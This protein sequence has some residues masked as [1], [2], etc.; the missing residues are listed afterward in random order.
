MATPLDDL[1][2]Q[3]ARR[4]ALLKERYIAQQLALLDLTPLSAKALGYHVVS[5]AHSLCQ[6]SG[7][8]VTI[9]LDSVRIRLCECLAFRKL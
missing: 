8:V 1:V 2:A 3:V 4:A 9:E 7:T 6:G 5:E